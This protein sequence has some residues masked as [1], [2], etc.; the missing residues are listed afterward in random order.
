MSLE[1]SRFV[2]CPRFTMA[3]SCAR[4]CGSLFRSTGTF[5]PS[6]LLA[7]WKANQIV[8]DILSKDYHDSLQS[9]ILC[10]AWLR[11]IE[12]FAAFHLK[13]IPSHSSIE[14]VWVAQSYVCL[15]I[16]SKAQN[17]NAKM[18]TIE[19][20]PAQENFMTKRSTL[21]FGNW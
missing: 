6:S 7:C 4:S 8:F 15:E 12:G 21:C 20:F 19:E 9:F 1:L 3:T 13:C 17:Q 18:P 16:W 5:P 2:L 10:I 14:V 11:R